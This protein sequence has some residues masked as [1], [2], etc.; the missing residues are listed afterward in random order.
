[1]GL[2]GQPGLSGY[3]VSFSCV[4]Y[5]K[6]LYTSEILHDQSHK[7][8]FELR[9]PVL[10]LENIINDKISHLIYIGQPFMFIMYN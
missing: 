1:M 7:D 2:E 9:T 10:K 5:Y 4:L 3:P 6:T 8:I